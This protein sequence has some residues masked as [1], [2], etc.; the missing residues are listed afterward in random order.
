MGALRDPL[1]VGKNSSD[2]KC[3]KK[4]GLEQDCVDLYNLPK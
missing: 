2:V 1:H 3:S 4:L